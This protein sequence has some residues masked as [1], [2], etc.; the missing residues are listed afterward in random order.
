[1]DK[2]AISIKEK[3]GTLIKKFSNRDKNNK[4]KVK[5]GGNTFVWNTLYNG[6]ETP[7]DMIF[8]S[9]SFSNSL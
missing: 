6:P 4:L 8:W 7:K 1:M 9:A 2:V 5:K 3:D